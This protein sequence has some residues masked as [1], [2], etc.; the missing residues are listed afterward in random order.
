MAAAPSS[1]SNSQQTFTFT[2]TDPNGIANIYYMQVQINVGYYSY[3]SCYLHFSSPYTIW[4]LNDSASAWLGPLSFFSGGQSLT[5]IPLSNSQ[6]QINSANASMSLSADTS[7]A[8][9]VLPMTASSTFVGNNTISAIAG[10]MVGA[11][12]Y[13]WTSWVSLGTWAPYPP[14][15]VPPQASQ[16]SPSSGSGASQSFQ[17]ALSDANGYR[18]LNYVWLTFVNGSNSCSV[19]YYAGADW[20]QMSDSAG[21]YQWAY[22]NGSVYTYGPGSPFCSLGIPA[23]NASGNSLTL[24]LPLSFALSFAGSINISGWVYDKA[25]QGAAVPASTWIVGNPVPALATISPISATAGSGAFTLTVTGSN[26]IGSSVVRWNG[27]GRTTTCVSPT[28]LSAAVT[29]ADV[30]SAGTATVTV[31]NPTPGGGTSNG[32][33]FTINNPVPAL[34]TISPTSATAGSGAFT[35]TVNGSNFVGSSVVRWNGGGRTTTYVSS[36]QL[37][38]A[39]TAADVASAGTATVT[40]F[41]PA[42]GGGTSNGASFTINPANNNPAPTLSRIYPT[43]SVAGSSTFT[44]I[45]D[46]ANFGAASVVRWNGSDRATIYNSLTQQ[47]TATITAADVASAGTATVTVFNPAPGGG[48]SG[49]ASFTVQPALHI[50][51]ATLEINLGWTPL[52]RYTET[53]NNYI[54]YCPSGDTVQ[55]CIKR[56]LQNYYNQ[57]AR[58]V[59][60]SFA[61]AGGACS[62]VFNSG[63][64]L[65]QAWLNNLHTFLADVKS[66]GYTAIIPNPSM[67]YS[68]RN[69]GDTNCP[70]PTDKGDQFVYP[71]PPHAA[72]P[73]GSVVRTSCNSSPPHTSYLVFVPWLPYG[74]DIGSGG[75]T[76]D[77][78]EKNNAYH[79]AVRNNAEVNPDPASRFWGWQPYF[80]LVQELINSAKG[81]NL[82]I[83]EFE[84]MGEVNLLD[85]P[86]MGH[87][88]YD[89][90]YTTN[91]PTG[92]LA[93]DVLGTVQDMFNNPTTG[94]GT[95]AGS[96]VTY[97]VTAAFPDLPAT[98][99]QAWS[100]NTYDC[101]SVYGD[102]AMIVLQSELL[103]ALGG[104][105]VGIPDY[106]D[107]SHG[108]ACGG[109]TTAPGDPNYTPMAPFLRSYSYSQFPAIID[110]H[111]YPCIDNPY[112]QALTGTAAC[113]LPGLPNVGPIGSTVN[114]PS[115]FGSATTRNFFND[116][117]NLLNSFS[118]GGWRNPLPGDPNK[119]SLSNASV[120][121]GETS[122]TQ[123]PSEQV[124]QDVHGSYGP[125]PTGCWTTLPFDATMA[126]SNVNGFNGYG[127]TSSLLYQNAA[128]RTAFRPWEDLM[129]ERGCLPLETPATGLNKVNPPYQP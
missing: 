43:L 40:V 2:F 12:S 6:C 127:G 112:Y 78:W 108:L 58:A 68:G 104:G 26:F 100:A 114:L 5:S 74:F 79:D 129:R 9:Y 15:N 42:P 94:F 67:G 55:N 61:M 88:I 110:I 32:A 69:W 91:P 28:Q 109:Q 4:L 119:A 37:T 116:V 70:G 126:Y 53:N 29:A 80:N 10:Y 81:A 93:A 23:V 62:T 125:P 39:I 121:L 82:A 17:F 25:W 30:A 35:L 45:A 85:F 115:D 16:A 44:L 51:P 120:V 122:W 50:S 27:G 66:I 11:S 46:G 75:Y 117:W 105:L 123:N 106:I 24:T 76:P 71:P 59:R 63:G 1:S 103:A 47:L 92:Q 111:A 22:L 77:C 87:L 101:G 56:Y 107:N 48:T 7:T 86:V 52:D 36:T 118:V 102:S 54:H 19:Y 90:D 33:S 97:S 21:N 65:N 64:S 20:V 99:S 95:G 96:R 128:A 98:D 31:F 14:Q 41:T 49:G 73:T 60:F 84:I 124:V 89:W 8:T 83:S 57:G 72:T 13:A 18:Y 3:N 34:A 38:A 113:F